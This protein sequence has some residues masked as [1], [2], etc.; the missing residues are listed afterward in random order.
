MSNRVSYPDYLTYDG[1]HRD[2]TI[3]SQ[4][5]PRPTLQQN[6]NYY[7][8]NRLLEPHFSSQEESR[9]FGAANFCAFLG[10]TIEVEHCLVI[11][12]ISS[13]RRIPYELPQKAEQDLYKTATDE[14]Y[15]AEQA[16]Q[17]LADLRNHFHL[18]R[19]EKY[20]CP[21]F[22]HRLEHQRSL[23]V[24]PIHRDLITI[25]NGVVTE[26]RISIELSKFAA[27][28]YL[29]GPVRTICRTHAEDEA[30]HA[31][32]FRALGRWL[33]GEFDEATRTAAA[34]FIS[35]STIA[36]SL[37]DVD[38][39]ATILHQSTDRSLSECKKLVFAIYTEDVL[40]D[41]MLVAARPTVRFLHDLGVDAYLP[42]SLVLE[43]E[44]KKLRAEMAVL[45]AA[46][47]KA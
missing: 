32:Q 33:W 39:M 44:R 20:R 11:P 13:L 26:T 12:A 4:E 37:P 35:A 6:E 42:F 2:P 5:Y 21:L 19:A 24:N 23:E 46:V 14:G 47:N 43:E 3:L 16:L 36:R 7:P 45:R 38:R 30:I 17:F 15:H 8:V 25:L 28:K 10:D 27:D 1:V 29:A 41:E 18:T 34:A 9:K 31:S 22:L 40:I